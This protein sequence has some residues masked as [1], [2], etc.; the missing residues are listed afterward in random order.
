MVAMTRMECLEE[1]DSIAAL[2]ACKSFLIRRIIYLD[3]GRNIMCL[4]NGHQ[5][6]GVSDIN[7]LLILSAIKNEYRKTS[8]SGKNTGQT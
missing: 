2:L 5:S 4:K 8:I 3:L 6:P 7:S 1:E